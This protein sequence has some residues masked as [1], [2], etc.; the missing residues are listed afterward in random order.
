RLAAAGSHLPVLSLTVSQLRNHVEAAI[1]NAHLTV[2]IG[3]QHPVALC[4]EIAGH[5][6]VRLVFDRAQ[7]LAV[8]CERLN[9]AVSAVGDDQ[10]RRFSPKVDPLAVGIVQ[11]AVALAWLA[12][13]PQ[14]L[15]SER[16]AEHV[17]RAVAI[18]DIEVAI[19]GEGNIGRHEIDRTLRVI[20]V[21]PRISVHPDLFAGE[22]SFHDP[23][24]VD[25]AVIQEFSTAFAAQLQSVCPAAKALAESAHEAPLFI[26]YDNRLAAHA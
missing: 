15:S 13:L 9:A 26:E 14:E 19:R 7:M 12:D 5:A 24:P 10:Q 3:T 16:K 1:E 4:V 17:V 20:R 22:R 6:Q 21:F 11:F 18:A 2:Q 8:E 23:A 25:V